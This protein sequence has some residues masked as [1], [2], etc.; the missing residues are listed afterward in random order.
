MVFIQAGEKWV[1][2]PPLCWRFSRLAAQLPFILATSKTEGRNCESLQVCT[3]CQK[4]IQRKQESPRSETQAGGW[5]W[6]PNNSES[7]KSPKGCMHEVIE[8]A[9]QS[10]LA[11]LQVECSGISFCR[12][13][14]KQKNRQWKTQES[15]QMK[16]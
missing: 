13:L 4:Q 10:S 11:A 9:K 6:T 2:I 1:P 16:L 12:S 3:L 8:L 5:Y 7:V 15:R 14:G